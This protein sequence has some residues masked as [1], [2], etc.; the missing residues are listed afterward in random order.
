MHEIKFNEI[1]PLSIG[2]I[3]QYNSEPY[4]IY[5]IDESGLVY[6]NN[7]DV[8]NIG[9]PESKIRPI[10]ITIQ[11]MDTCNFKIESEPEKIFIGDKLIQVRTDYLL[12]ENKF[13]IDFK[14][15][16]FTDYDNDD[17]FLVNTFDKIDKGEEKIKYL[18][19]VQNV[20]KKIYNFEMVSI[21]K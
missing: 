8:K 11:V 18:H 10:L 14:I 7:P 5:D 20:F 12:K 1:N 13:D 4:T 2:N 15:S 16:V 19:Q 17:P 9:I 21:E 3:V 6:L